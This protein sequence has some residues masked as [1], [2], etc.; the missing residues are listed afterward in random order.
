MSPPP[1]TPSTEAQERFLETLAKEKILPNPGEPPYLETFPKEDR[2]RELKTKAK[3]T[4][5]CTLRNQAMYA[6]TEF[7]AG[8]KEVAEY[9]N[10]QRT[11]AI[12]AHTKYLEDNLYS[13][14]RE[15]YLE[16]V[17]KSLKKIQD[18]I[19]KTLL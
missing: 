12:H 15:T 10:R 3:D 17:R 2:E 8:D 5:T 19:I 14:Q 1:K 16:T 11:S 9:F 6:M 18:K 4:K 7:G 13:V